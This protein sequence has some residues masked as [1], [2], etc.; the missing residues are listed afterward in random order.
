MEITPSTTLICIH[1]SCRDQTGQKSVTMGV[2]GIKLMYLDLE[3]LGRRRRPPLFRVCANCKM[4]PID[5]V[6]A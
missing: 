2:E 3:L 1:F 4:A 6:E 5:H